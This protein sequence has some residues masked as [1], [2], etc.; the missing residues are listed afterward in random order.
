MTCKNPVQKAENYFNISR[1][2]SVPKNEENI[3]KLEMNKDI[4]L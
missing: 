4:K 2:A 3:G 1:N